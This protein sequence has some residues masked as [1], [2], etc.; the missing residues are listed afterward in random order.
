MIHNSSKGQFNA[1]DSNVSAVEDQEIVLKNV[2]L[3]TI[4]NA[5]SSS[6]NHDATIIANLLQNNKLVVD[7]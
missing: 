7:H 6:T 3:D 5:A 4:Y 2:N 1:T